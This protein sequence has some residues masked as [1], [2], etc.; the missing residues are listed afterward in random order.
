MN[1][2]TKPPYMGGNRPADY[3]EVESVLAT[4]TLSSRPSR[5]P[6]Y[7]AEAEAL[8][9]LSR[10][11]SP[12]PHDYLHR[13]CELAM[14][15][16]RAQSAGISIMESE[17]V[18]PVFRWHAVAGAMAPHLW[19]T[20]PR[21]FAPCGVTV[22]RDAPQLFLH[23]ERYYSY[24]RTLLPPISELLLIPFHLNEKPIGTIW[25]VGGDESPPF[26]REDVRLL[27]NLATS[28]SASLNLLQTRAVY[29]AANESLANAHEQLAQQVQ[30]FDT[31]LSSIVDFTYTFDLEGRFTFV[32]QALLDLWNLE[33]EDALGKTFFEL[34]YPTELAARLHSQIQAVIDTGQPVR[35]ETPY[36]GA[37][38]ARQ[39][40]YILVPVHGKDQSVV[41]VA[42]STRDITERHRDREEG[43]ALL[44]T[45]E[46][47]RDRL[48]DLFMYAPAFMAVMRG[49]EHRFER[50]NPQ[51]YQLVG[52]RDVIGKTIREAFPEVEGQGFIEILD[53]VYETGKPFFGQDMRVLLQDQE[54]GASLE[55]F[56]DFV[57]Q[58]LVEADGSVSG[59]F[60]HGVDLTERKHAE[61]EIKTLNARLQ[62]MMTETHHRVKNNLQIISALVEI[63]MEEGVDTVPATSMARIGQHTRSLAALHDLLTQES[64]TGAG[65]QSL[66]AKA[67]IEKLLPHL[68]AS[69]ISRTI[70]YIGSDFSITVAQAA[71]LSLLV[72]ELISNAVKHGRGDIELSLTATDSI[73]RLEVSDDGPGFP[74]GFDRHTSANTG[75]SLIDSTGRYDLRGT[76]AYE[77]RPAGGAR[78]IVCFPIPNADSDQPNNP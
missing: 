21:D 27:T 43:A 24:I 68:R 59:I 7:K 41:A 78:V 61:E 13:V 44:K 40:E 71:S 76:I 29:E 12:S 31:V 66:S 14:G 5:Q 25:I 11:L 8:R 63:Q 47:E 19:G 33:L 42:G 56:L 52:H 10:E 32:N 22:D 73:A 37:S 58:P 38:G 26:E 9:S 70:L 17:G 2:P 72:S 77:N 35:D 4:A 67:M 20:T 36:N 3:A 23:P 18:E 45:L 6:D 57:Y 69:A 50:A 48:T 74:E 53:R 34:D 30:L 54:G 65:R 1:V 64:R 60:A 16:C 15:L 49:T 51:V 55:H 28:A 46:V 75:M 39:Y 62:R